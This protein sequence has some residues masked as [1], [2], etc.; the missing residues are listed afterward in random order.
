MGMYVLVHIAIGGTRQKMH[1]K[2]KFFGFFRCTGWKSCPEQEKIIRVNCNGQ[3]LPVHVLVYTMRN[4]KMCHKPNSDLT[5]HAYAS[6]TTCFF[7]Q[8]A[9]PG[10]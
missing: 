9:Q 8:I 6:Y 7:D 1:W 3:N 4:H 2:K 5:V 10:L